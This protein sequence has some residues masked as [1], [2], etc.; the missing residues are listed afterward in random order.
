[1]EN[2]A[3][4]CCRYSFLGFYSFVRCLEKRI[5]SIKFFLYLRRFGVVSS[6]LVEETMKMESGG[7][8]GQSRCCEPP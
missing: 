4:D 2:K 7:S 8:P 3:N 1:M 6:A 5:Y